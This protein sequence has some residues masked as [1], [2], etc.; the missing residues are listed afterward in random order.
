MQRTERET[1]SSHSLEDNLLSCSSACYFGTEIYF[2]SLCSWEPVCLL[3]Y[4]FIGFCKSGHWFLLKRSEWIPMHLHFY[5]PPLLFLWYLSD[6]GCCGDLNHKTPS[7][8]INLCYSTY[9]HYFL[10]LSLMTVEESLSYEALQKRH[11]K[12]NITQYE[13]KVRIQIWLFNSLFKSTCYIKYYTVYTQ[14][15]LYIFRDGLDISNHLDISMCG[16]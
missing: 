1:L 12:F 4:L 9:P 13:H 6:C 10:S 11:T 14:G 5:N 15:K 3:V 7:P 16:H 8:F 2:Y